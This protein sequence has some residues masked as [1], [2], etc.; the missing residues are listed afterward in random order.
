MTTY[1][2]DEA[3][4]VVAAATEREPLWTDDD[5]AWLL[6]LLAEQRETCAGCGHPLDECRDPAGEKT[7]RLVVDTCHACMTLDMDRH[8]QAEKKR[9]P[10]GR[11]TA[12]RRWGG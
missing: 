12:T 5:R 4:R 10:M 2:Y 1:E 11:Y 7:W 9:P 6:A 8:N 3:G